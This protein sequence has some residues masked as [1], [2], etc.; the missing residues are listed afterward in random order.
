MYE[1][2]LS[3]NKKETSPSGEVSFE[4]LIIVLLSDDNF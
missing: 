1:K 4:E 2:M 3:G